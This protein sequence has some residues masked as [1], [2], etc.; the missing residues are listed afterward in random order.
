ML[1]S[2][3]VHCLIMKDVIKLNRKR[4]MSDIFITHFSQGVNKNDDIRCFEKLEVAFN[5]K[6]KKLRGYIGLSENSNNLSI[7]KYLWLICLPINS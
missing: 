4:N 5:I 3:L 2:H 1:T 7:S 6:A